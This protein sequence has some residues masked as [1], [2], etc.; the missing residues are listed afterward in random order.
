MDLLYVQML[1]LGVCEK[2]DVLQQR[3]FISMPC[4]HLFDLLALRMC[5]SAGSRVNIYVVIAV[6]FM[7]TV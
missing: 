2:K 3:T 7:N 6:T 4:V 5:L 1:I